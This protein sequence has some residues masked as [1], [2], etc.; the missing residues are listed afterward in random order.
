METPVS[1]NMVDGF[2]KIGRIGRWPLTDANQGKN[3]SWGNGVSATCRLAELNVEAG[4][5]VAC[6]TG[7]GAD[8]PVEGRAVGAA[9]DSGV[10]VAEPPHATRKTRNIEI[11]TAGFLRVESFMT[12]PPNIG[13]TLNFLIAGAFSDEYPQALLT[14]YVL[15]LWIILF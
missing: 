15:L 9:A 4:I 11:S 2:S 3:V 8:P 6:G 1:G 12:S 5:A 10:L 14:I 7:V 13:T